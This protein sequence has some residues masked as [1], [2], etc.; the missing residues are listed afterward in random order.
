ML[1]VSDM[2]GVIVDSERHWVPLENERILPQTVASG[3][4]TASE[5]TGMNVTD[6]CAY[7]DTE[8]GTTMNEA[9]F[10]GL[11]DEVA[12][13]LYTERVALQDGFE[14]L[15]EH[16]HKQDI[17]VAIVSSSPRRWIRFVL[18]RFAL[19]ELIDEVV[20]AEDIDG[21]SKPA[22]D[23]YQYAASQLTIPAEQCVAVEDS[24]HGIA[25]A[26]AAEMYSL[27]YRTDVN[28]DQDL[29]AADRVVAG[30]VELRNHLETLCEDQ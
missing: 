14:G 10:I 29:A 24:A 18:D 16:L 30:P 26:N 21:S 5:I 27:G 25:A 2:D 13:E 9:E 15:C 12:E 23:I 22:P 4:V 6:L 1:S 19:H 3:E 8:Y 7:L 11:Y 28:A 20:S 17:V